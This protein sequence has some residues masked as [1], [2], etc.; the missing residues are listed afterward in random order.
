MTN[1][2]RVNTSF[3]DYIDNNS[4][5]YRDKKETMFLV[6]SNGKPCIL[7]NMY[8]MEQEEKRRSFYTIKQYSNNIAHL[9]RFCDFKNINFYSM[10]ND[11]F[12]EFSNELRNQVKKDNP[13]I[14]Y[15]SSNSL[16]AILKT[17]LDFLYFVGK[18]NLNEN[19]IY[20]AIRAFQ[21]SNEISLSNKNGTI[22]VDGWGHI[23]LANSSPLKKR[24]PISLNLINKLY[25]AIS[26]SKNSKFIKLRRINLLNILEATGARIGEIALLKIE[27]IDEVFNQNNSFLKMTT[28]KRRDNKKIRFVPINKI[29]LSQIK[30]YIKVHRQKIINNTIGKEKDHGYLFVSEL[31]GKPMTS[32]GLSNELNYIKKIANIDEKACAHMFRH[33]YITKQF[34]NLVQQYNLENQDDFK[35]ALLDIQTLKQQIQQITGHTSISSLDIYIDLAFKEITNFDVIIDKVQIRN[36]YESFENKLERI[37]RELANGALTIKEY[38]SIQQEL[39]KNK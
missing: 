19:F 6:H 5:I 4:L 16:N 37:N 32:S 12:I 8:I 35:N 15:R 22:K 33:R 21:R 17:C 3:I 34:I 31:T 27:D 20:D 11:L 7:G 36:K 2:V 30:S 29:D 24:E 9:I 39:L 26:T 18:I 23:C 38:L 14:K 28:L 1:A 13:I 10:T 25:E